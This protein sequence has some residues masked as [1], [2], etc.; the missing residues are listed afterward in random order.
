M[1][2]AVSAVWGGRRREREGEGEREG[3]EGE[4]GKGREREGEGGTVS[5]QSYISYS[6]STDLLSL[7]NLSLQR[8]I[9]LL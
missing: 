6:A 2:A 8:L 1:T 3:K 7:F 9:L 5:Y 4:R